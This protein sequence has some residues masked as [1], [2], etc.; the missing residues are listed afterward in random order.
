ME[1]VFYKDQDPFIIKILSKLG[2]EKKLFSLIK[3]P[4]NRATISITLNGERM[5]PH[6]I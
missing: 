3:G 5:L 2:I 4:H 6:K 1:T